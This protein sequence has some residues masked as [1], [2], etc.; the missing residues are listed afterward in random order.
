MVKSNKVHSRISN[1]SKTAPKFSVEAFHLS[2]QS[3]EIFN[4]SV[5]KNIYLN[6]THVR[7]PLLVSIGSRIVNEIDCALLAV[8]LAL[9]KSR[10][11]HVY[12]SNFQVLFPSPRD[13]DISIDNRQAA[14]DYMLKVI[15]RLASRNNL[16]LP[17]DKDTILRLQDLHLLEYLRKY[18]SSSTFSSL[19]NYLAMQRRG[20]QKLESE[21]LLPS[22][23]HLEASLLLGSFV[24]ESDDEL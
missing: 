11:K 5:A 16:H 8:P 7:T 24:V 14:N 1:N 18:F 10:S 21:V 6:A 19:C 9:Q 12:G 2:K 13:L 22:S 20:R 23:V 4:N 17:L 15:K 3:I